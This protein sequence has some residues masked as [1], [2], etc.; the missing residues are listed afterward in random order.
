MESIWTHTEKEFRLDL[1]G[2][3][4][5]EARRIQ[6]KRIAVI[7]WGILASEIFDPDAGGQVND[8]CGPKPT[9]P[10]AAEDAILFGVEEQPH[11]LLSLD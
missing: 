1:P 8:S 7:L 10:R 11:G 6:A 2:K 5:R 3:A 4:A 9:E